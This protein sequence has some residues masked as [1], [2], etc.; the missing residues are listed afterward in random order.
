MVIYLNSYIITK[1]KHLLIALI[2]WINHQD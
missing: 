1:F 2:I